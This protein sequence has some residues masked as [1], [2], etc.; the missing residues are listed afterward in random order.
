MKVL[1]MAVVALYFSG[2]ALSQP[3]P[4]S[5]LPFVH[6][7]NTELPSRATSTMINRL[8]ILADGSR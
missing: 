3:Q 8:Y 1:Y 7:L 2:D 6:P 4:M 5:M